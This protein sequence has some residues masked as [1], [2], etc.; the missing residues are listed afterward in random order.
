VFTVSIAVAALLALD[1]L[2]RYHRRMRRERGAEEPPAEPD[3]GPISVR[4][5]R[6]A[7]LALTAGPAPAPFTGPDYADQGC[8]HQL[9]LY[10]PS[11]IADRD[12]HRL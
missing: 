5:W 2:G 11:E 6:P 8:D 12:G 10:V 9:P 1:V 4:S 3:P 7:P